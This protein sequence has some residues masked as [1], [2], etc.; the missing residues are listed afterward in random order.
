M[1]DLDT[2]LVRGRVY[3]TDEAKLARDRIND[4]D[5]PNA[6]RPE[7]RVHLSGLGRSLRGMVTYLSLTPQE[8][9]SGVGQFEVKISFA[10][11]PKGVTD[12]L[13]VSFDIVVGRADNV[14]VV[15]VRFV[16]LEGPKAYVQK[17]VNGKPVRTEVRLGLSDNQHYEV[18]DGLS[19]GDVIQWETAAK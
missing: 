10:T 5:V 14:L 11:P 13:Q 17:L 2:L 7:A 8:S 4:A 18:L 1:A 9:S 6:E 15:P 19:E 12:G 16:E 3:Q